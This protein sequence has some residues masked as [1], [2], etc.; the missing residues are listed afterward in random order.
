LLQAQAGKRAAV[1]AGISATSIFA[2]PN[3]RDESPAAENASPAAA[4]PTI[5]LHSVRFSGDIV[6]THAGQVRVLVA[7]SPSIMNSHPVPLN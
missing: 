5:R 6:S 2:G 1:S 3:Y 7:N 4:M